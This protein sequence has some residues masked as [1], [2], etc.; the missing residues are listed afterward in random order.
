MDDLCEDA[1]CR[2][3][4]QSERCRVDDQSSTIFDD[5][6]KNAALDGRSIRN[7]LVWVDTPTWF[8]IKV[9]LDELLNFRDTGGTPNKYNLPIQLGVIIQTREGAYLVNILLLHFRI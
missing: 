8:L 5:S 3:D 9:I 7:S 6:R 2:F 1:T 4:T